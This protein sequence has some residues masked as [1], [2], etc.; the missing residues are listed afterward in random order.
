MAS[1]YPRQTK[2]SGEVW[3]VRIKLRSGQWYRYNT[4]IPV[5]RTRDGELSAVSLRKG[6]KAAERLQAHEDAGDDPFRLTEQNGHRGFLATAEEYCA[7]RAASWSMKT[8]ESVRYTIRLLRE[9]LGEFEIRSVDRGVVVKFRKWLLGRR[10]SPASVNIHLRN[11]RAFVNWVAREVEIGWDPPRIQQIRVEGP[12]HR[13]SLTP[14]E[15]ERVIV[16]AATMVINGCLVWPYFLFLVLTGMRRNEALQARWPWIHGDFIYIPGPLTKTQ[17]KRIVPITGALRSL[18]MILPSPHDGKLF[19]GLTEAVSKRFRKAVLIAEIGR[20][21][22]LHNLRDTF[23][24]QA[25]VAGVPA[26]LVAKICGNS[27]R[28]IESH[29]SMFTTDEISTTMQQLNAIQQFPHGTAIAPA[30]LTRNI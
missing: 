1:F 30:S 7:D 9:S 16:A 5:E 26:F 17:Q 27:V 14:E 19:P 10:Y 21:L 25:L 15:L 11:L 28:V 20:P 8:L 4:K 6:L 18:L 24:V 29:Y 2:T 12:T 3:Y 23:I 13:D 22:H